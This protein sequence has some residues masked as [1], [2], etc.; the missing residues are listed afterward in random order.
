MYIK[1]E[2]H[3]NIFSRYGTT[4]VMVKLSCYE[5]VKTKQ[6]TRLSFMKHSNT[7]KAKRTTLKNKTTTTHTSIDIESNTQQNNNK[8]NQHIISPR[9]TKVMKNTYTTQ[10]IAKQQIIVCK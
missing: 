7:R 1:W 9:N 3:Y 2:E 4:S 6:Y 5:T 10:R 8:Q